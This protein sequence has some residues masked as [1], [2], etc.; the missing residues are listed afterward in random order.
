M[1]VRGDD[2]NAYKSDRLA[3]GAAPATVNRE[4]AALKRAYTLAV[5]DE[6]ILHR[7][8]IAMLRENNARRGFL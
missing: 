8:P 4:L 3:A 1:S 2:I 6:K 5:R 7:P